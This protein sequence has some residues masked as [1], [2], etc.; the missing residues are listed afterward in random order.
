MHPRF[1]F[2]EGPSGLSNIYL[3]LTNFLDNFIQR[4]ALLNRKVLLFMNP[5]K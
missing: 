5:K 2:S 1:G 3:L 4:K